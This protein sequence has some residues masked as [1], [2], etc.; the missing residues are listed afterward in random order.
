MGSSWLRDTTW[1]SCIGRQILYHLNHQGSPHLIY[2]YMK[3][4]C[5]PIL[6]DQ[7]HIQKI[8]NKYWKILSIE[9][10]NCQN[11]YWL[12]FWQLR[13]NNLI[14]EV[15]IINIDKQGLING[16][17]NLDWLSSLAISI[18][19]YMTHKWLFSDI[20]ISHH[21]SS[22][23][24]VLDELDFLSAMGCPLLFRSPWNLTSSHFSSCVWMSAKET[25]RW[26]G[27]QGEKTR[28]RENRDWL[29]LRSL[30]Q[31]NFTLQ[32]SPP[33]KLKGLA[34]RNSHYPTPVTL[35]L[36]SH[37]STILEYCDNICICLKKHLGL[38]VLLRIRKALPFPPYSLWSI[39]FIWQILPY[40]SRLLSQCFL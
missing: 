13:W 33:L 22:F 19:V 8:I 39:F 9:L 2:T 38:F 10:W 37:Y 18:Q 29:R 11:P 36:I 27:E 35:R 5:V 34:N 1:V 4:T 32:P 40:P 14:L 3:Y 28:W 26:W 20:K 6:K 25:G 23:D 16:T 31:V 24:P 12:N 17:K 30:I 15:T 7:L 21:K